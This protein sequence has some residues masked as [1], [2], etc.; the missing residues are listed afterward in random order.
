MA[1]LSAR[2]QGLTI[3]LSSINPFPKLFADLRRRPLR[4]HPAGTRRALQLWGRGRKR[5]GLL[6]RAKAWRVATADGQDCLT[7]ELRATNDKHPSQDR[8]VLWRGR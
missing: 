8:R 1:R 2:P 4:A 5:T 6:W 7:T 3:A